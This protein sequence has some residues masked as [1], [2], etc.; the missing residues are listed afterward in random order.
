MTK[1]A[2]EQD[3]RRIWNARFPSHPSFG[4]I[5][6]EVWQSAPQLAQ[7]ANHEIERYNCSVAGAVEMI[8]SRKADLAAA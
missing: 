1:Y 7:M 2:I 8:L 5:D 3:V 6:E 4:R